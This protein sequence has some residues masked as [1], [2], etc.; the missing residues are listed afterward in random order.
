[1]ISPLLLP[2]ESKAQFA[3]DGYLVLPSVLDQGDIAILRREADR[4][5]RRR[6]MKKREQ[7]GNGIFDSFRNCLELSDTFVPLLTQRTVLGAV[8]SIMGTNIRLTTSQLVFRHPDS[9]DSPQT[10]IA[11]WHRDMAPATADLGHDKV[12]L[13]QIKCMYYLTDCIASGRGSTL[14]VPASN[15]APT[16]PA[17]SD[18]DLDPP[19]ALELSVRAGDCILFENRTWHA[20]GPN[21]STDTRK[22]L[23]LG[24]GYRWLHSHDYRTVPSRFRDQLSEVELFLLGQTP[25]GPPGFRVGGWRNPLNETITHR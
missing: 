11:R 9:P 7:K 10:R 1:M 23:I 25:P 14:I 20:G 5:M 24:Y 17:V 22:A 4:I 13:M 21:T 16:G 3:R 19:G 8:L 2:S 18:G 15:H 12:P 6:T